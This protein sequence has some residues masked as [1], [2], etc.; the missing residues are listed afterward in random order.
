MKNL[1]PVGYYDRDGWYMNTAALEVDR[2]R[3]SYSSFR[4]ADT[5]SAM[6][7][8]T[9]QQ[10][11]IQNCSGSRQL[12]CNARTGTFTNDLVCTSGT[13]CGIFMSPE[14]SYAQ[15]LLQ[16]QITALQLRLKIWWLGTKNMQEFIQRN[17]E[18]EN[19]FLFYWWSPDNFI[20]SFTGITRGR[21]E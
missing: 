5:I 15:D 12:L 4:Q 16:R 2:A 18:S 7:N 8:I 1:G 6:N 11:M 9:L 10:R 20:A 21:D 14:T 13:D 3:G 17:T 19:P